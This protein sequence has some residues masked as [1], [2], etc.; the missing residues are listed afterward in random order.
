M[1]TSNT[2]YELFQTVK[3]KKR[4]NSDWILT[5]MRH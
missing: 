2:K 5:K 3:K 1:L 4:E